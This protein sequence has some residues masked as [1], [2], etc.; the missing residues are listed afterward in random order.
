[1]RLA[2]FAAALIAASVMSANAQTVITKPG[3]YNNVGGT[4]FGPGGQTQQ[5]IGG[6]LFHNDGNG[7]TT[8]Y[9]KIGGTT[10]GSD[11]TTYNKVGGTTFGSNGT[12]SNTIG[13]TTFING[14]NGKTTVC[15]TIGTSTFCN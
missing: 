10:F 7:N 2:M 9:N 8:T 15:Q 13:G 6:T 11:G 4:T 3:V 1:M 14:P 12:T 5:R